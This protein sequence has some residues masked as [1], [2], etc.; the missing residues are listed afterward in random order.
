MTLPLW[1]LILSLFIPRISFIIAYF[2]GDLPSL[3]LSGWIAP[4]MGVLIPRALVLILIF[5]DRGMSAWL[6]PLAGSRANGRTRARHA[7]IGG[8]ILV[9]LPW[10][11][12]P[13]RVP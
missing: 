1:F 12:S 7:N 10:E 2:T 6:L 4:I 3:V 13:F 5:Q 8:S 11:N 9:A